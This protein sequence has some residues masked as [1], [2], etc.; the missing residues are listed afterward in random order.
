VTDATLPT[1]PPLADTADMA[2]VHRVFREAIAAATALI[3]SAVGDADRVERVST[4]Y[5]N[6]LRFLDAHHGGEDAILWPLLCERAPGQAAEVMAVADEHERVHHALDVAAERLAA[7][8]ASGDLDAGASLAGSLAE[9]GAALVHHLDDEERFVV[10]LAAQH[11]T[12]PEWGQLPTHAM[13]SF[14][15]DKLWLILGLVIEQMRPEQI[16][17][18]RMHMPPPLVEM[19]DVVGRRQ[20]DEFVAALRG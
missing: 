8:R 9:L 19:W 2:Q 10:P 14:D 1:A 11:V 13:R 17:M 4:Y 16:E 18:M 15:G 20:F 7:W 12:A 6:V 3:G 5:D